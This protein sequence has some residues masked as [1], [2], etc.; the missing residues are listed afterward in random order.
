MVPKL[1]GLGLRL[2]PPSFSVL[3]VERYVGKSHAGVLTNDPVCKLDGLGLRIP[4]PTF[5]VSDMECYVGKSPTGVLANDPVWKE[6]KYLHDN[7][8]FRSATYIF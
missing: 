6:N 4:L 7:K 8:S 3:D 2:P 1:D 5:S